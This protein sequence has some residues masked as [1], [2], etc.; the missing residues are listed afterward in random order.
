MSRIQTNQ[1]KLPVRPPQDR[2]R[3]YLPLRVGGKTERALA[4]TGA[5]ENVMCEALAKELDLIVNKSKMG[6][7]HFVNAIGETMEAIGHTTIRCNLENDEPQSFPSGRV[8][9]FWV[10]SKLAEP[11]VVGRNFLESTGTLTGFR[12]RLQKMIAPQGVA[13]RILHLELPRWRINSTINDEMVLANPDTGSDLDL[14]SLAYVQ[15]RGFKIQE[16]E[17]KYQFVEFADGSQKKLSGTVLVRF[18]IG[19]SNDE[20]APRHFY[21]LEGLTSD[22]LL[23]NNTLEDFDAFNTYRGELVDLEEYD[24]DTDF[25]LIRW[26]QKS[27]NADFLDGIFQDFE[28]SIH[29]TGRENVRWSQYDI[30]CADEV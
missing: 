9:R 29:N 8:A 4:D 2:I 22:V 10:F 20:E 7:Y 13:L 19:S 21:V 16:V 5:Q 15:H 30:S 17:P 18:N 12:H 25:H 3:S 6:S 1:L 14:M 11:L 27:G 24:N 23:G 28:F 26:V